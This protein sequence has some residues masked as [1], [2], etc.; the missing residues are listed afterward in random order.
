MPPGGA[1]LAA[2]LA[3]ALAIS[4]YQLIVVKALPNIPDVFSPAWPQ[5]SVVCS[6]F[7]TDLANIHDGG[8]RSRYAHFARLHR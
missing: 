5:V 3:N 7:P 6:G 4:P 8:L 1:R 2:F